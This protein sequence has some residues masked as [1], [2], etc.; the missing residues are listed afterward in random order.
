MSTDTH[1]LLRTP[2]SAKEIRTALVKDPALADLGLADEGDW[3]GMGDERKRIS[4]AI[5]PWKDNDHDLIENGFETASV[6]ITLSPGWDEAGW[7]AYHRTFAALLRLT[8]GDAC[9]Q[10]QGGGPLG[11][12][13]QDGTVYVNPDWIGPE[14]LLDFGYN[15]ERIVVGIPPKKVE[16]AAQ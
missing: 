9:A 13:R 12:L 4:L 3:A 6:T 2:L 1:M 14:D 10:E 5:D 7:D 15:P 11:L 8:P 16:A